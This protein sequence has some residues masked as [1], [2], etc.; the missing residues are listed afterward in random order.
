MGNNYLGKNVL[1]KFEYNG[2]VVT[3]E[4]P[5]RNY[6]KRFG[7]VVYRGVKLETSLATDDSLIA[8]NFFKECI[9]SCISLAGFPYMLPVSP[10]RKDGADHKPYDDPQLCMPTAELDVSVRALNCLK[11]ENLYYVGDV[12]KAGRRVLKKVPN[13]GKGSLAEIETALETLGVSLPW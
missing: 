11:A 13:L 2:V 8:H 7:V 6:E 12:V 3:L 5:A 4:S 9:S 1:G 10:H